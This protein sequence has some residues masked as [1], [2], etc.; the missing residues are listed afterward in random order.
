MNK[1]R[2]RLTKLAMILVGLFVLALAA[3]CGG[4]AAPTPTPTSSSGAANNTPTAAAS[5]TPT[6]S[7]DAAAY[8]KG[9]TIRVIVPF[10]PGGGTDLIARAIAAEWSK[11]I[12]GQPKVV[13]DNKTPQTAGM[14]MVW[15]AK[16]DG[17]T[18]GTTATKGWYSQGLVS[19]AMYNASDWRILGAVTKF[20]MGW[21]VGQD[22]PYQ[23]LADAK[24][25]TTQFKNVITSTDP[26]Q[27]TGT[28]VLFFWL[29]DQL[30]LPYVAYGVTNQGSTT[31]ML[32]FDRGEVNM[33]ADG[34]G[35]SWDGLPVV[36]PGWESSGKIRPFVSM[37][38]PNITIPPSSEGPWTAKNVVDFLN[39][40][41]KETWLSLLPYPSWEKPFF[42][43]P[44]TPDDITNAL[45]DSFWQTMQDPTASAAI[46]KA[47]GSIPFEPTQGVADEQ[48][49]KA[50]APKYLAAWQQVATQ[51]QLEQW[52]TKYVH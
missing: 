5:S 36:R 18:V 1:S 51:T 6:P 24:G 37:T 4:G 40:S 38:N 15:T 42:L 27:F 12:P 20:E 41:Q 39:A 31:A 46:K 2:V 9:K 26:S 10:K 45:R 14:N 3:A 22:I 49:T 50:Q 29:A 30:D 34:G 44:N 47:M 13:V 21:M 16:P 11:F 19:G 35:G 32:A 25:G 8:F 43:P 48:E 28:D 33:I 7:F 17:L 52:K 23:T